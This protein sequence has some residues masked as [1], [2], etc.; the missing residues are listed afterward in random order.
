MKEKLPVYLENRIL[1][2]DNFKKEIKQNNYGYVSV[3]LLLSTLITLGS[4]L[5]I[6][7]FGNR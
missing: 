6:L 4:L 5:T 2:Q 3:T 1:P 7:I